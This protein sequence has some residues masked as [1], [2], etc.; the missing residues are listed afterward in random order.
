[1]LK[2][3][4]IKNTK[5]E[6]MNEEKN[7]GKILEMENK[8]YRNSPKL[9]LT[10]IMPIL[11]SYGILMLTI[12]LS[13]EG[14]SEDDK[15]II[16]FMLP[17]ALVFF[18]LTLILIFIRWKNMYYTLNEDG[19]LWEY[20]GKLKKV[21]KELKYDYI[22]SLNIKKSIISRIFKVMSV[23]FNLKSAATA[24]SDE[25]K[26]TLTK[27][28]MLRV[29]T[30]IDIK[31]N[32]KSSIPINPIIENEPIVNQLTVQK[33]F[34]LTILEYVLNL[35]TSFLFLIIITAIEIW[36]AIF[37]D[38]TSGQGLIIVFVV[39]PSVFKIDKMINNKVIVE[40]D[41]ISISGGLISRHERKLSFDNIV[42]QRVEKNRIIRRYRISFTTIGE[43]SGNQKENKNATLYMS[44]SKI[45]KIYDLVEAKIQKDEAQEIKLSLRPKIRYFILS[46]LPTWSVIVAI[47]LLL[48]LV[49]TW[50]YSVAFG[51][52]LLIFNLVRLL[53]YYVA[54]LQ[55][56]Q[57]KVIQST[58]VIVRVEEKFNLEDVNE[59][60]INQGVIARIF[61]FAKI[62]LSLSGHLN[63]KAINYIEKSK[64]NEVEKRLI[65]YISKNE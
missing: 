56:G 16:F 50:E 39:V 42:S 15:K 26:L 64:A 22:S 38:D 44:K 61:K 30:A 2:Y 54:R 40:E 65:D 7:M 60:T 59:I 37:F 18:V 14:M 34:T 24:Q 45:Q 36:S 43:L 35:W 9:I 19:I 8:R 25:F 5:G 47:L 33:T 48:V 51:A 12:F 62:N 23:G 11:G 4:Y 58:G 17:V 49:D 55:F 27:E 13:M 29:Q 1:M 52:I 57:T 21:K 28:N 31:S 10:W 46:K 32:I 41:Y 63:N 20:D 53:F 3:Y 6:E